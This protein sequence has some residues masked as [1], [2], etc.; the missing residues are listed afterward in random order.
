MKNQNQGKPSAPQYQGGSKNAIRGAPASLEN[1]MAPKNPRMQQQGGQGGRG[2]YGQP[3]MSGGY[4]P[5]MQQRQMQ[6]QMQQANAIRQQ[7]P[8][9]G[10]TGGQPMNA[11]PQPAISTR[12]PNQMAVPLS[13]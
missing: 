1:A 6:Q 8:R 11:R 10:G 5:Q 13:R 7:P 9:E 4:P 12:N 2:N 3:S